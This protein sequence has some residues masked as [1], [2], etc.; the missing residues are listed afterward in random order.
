MDDMSQMSCLCLNCN[1]PTTGNYCANCGQRT[2]FHRERFRDMVI[3]FLAHYF[4]YDQKFSRT[5]RKLLF[6]P[7]RLSLDYQAGRRSSYLNPI[8]L[9]I[10]ISAFTFL[11]FYTAFRPNVVEHQD[12]FSINWIVGNAGV[13]TLDQYDY[14]DT[15]AM[16]QVLR[17]GTR[18][19]MDSAV[20]LADR[21]PASLS[22]SYGLILFYK[23]LTQYC[24]R[25]H[26]FLFSHALNQVLQ[27]YIQSIP[28][29]FFLLM[30]W[31]GLLLHF[32]FYKRAHYFAD[33]VI[34]SLHFHSFS[35]LLL[36]LTLLLYYIP[37]IPFGLPLGILFFGTTAYLVLCCYHFYRRPWVV[38]VLIS[39][40]VWGIYLLSIWAVSILL[41]FL[42]LATG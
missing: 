28:K 34:L 13:E 40:T 11:V 39:L 18:P 30:P 4:H 15:L 19:V 9:Y 37:G 17:I 31:F 33:N 14:Y 6:H 36:I 23:Y 5:L 21:T 25:N 20:S 22:F 41:L 27:A 1:E 10:L 24:Y 29:L 16:K 42:T 35:F 7:G 32:F 8:Q 2:G 12:G 38:V 26:I 3:H